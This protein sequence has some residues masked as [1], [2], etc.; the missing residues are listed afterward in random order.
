M[1]EDKS[2]KILS[3]FSNLQ[4]EWVNENNRPSPDWPNAGRVEFKTYSMS[5]RK[6]LEPVLKSI[7]VVVNPG[8]KVG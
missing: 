8:E 3:C 7:N 5:Y 6:E 4:A 2:I 1:D